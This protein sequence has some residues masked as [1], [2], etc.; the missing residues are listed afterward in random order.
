MA[1]W[2]STSRS[3]APA[4]ASRRVVAL[5]RTALAVGPEGRFALRVLLACTLFAACVVSSS[6]RAAEPPPPQPPPFTFSAS[7]SGLRYFS[8]DLDGGGSIEMSRALLS[9]GV[10]RQFVPAFSATLNMSLD[11]QDW[12]FGTP[13]AFGSQAPWQDLRQQ[14]M[15]LRL[16]QA[17]SKTLVV[18]VQPFVEWALET[19]V[20][21]SDAMTYG[22]LA[23]VVK[24]FSPKFTLGGGAKV[25]RMFYNVRTTPFFILNWKISERFRIANAFPASPAGGGGIEFRYTP[26]TAWEFGVGGVMRTD[27]YRLANPGPYPAHIAEVHNKPI[28]LRVSR[29]LGGGLRAD[30]YGA[31]LIGGNIEITDG[32]GNHVVEDGYGTVPALAFSLVGRF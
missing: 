1:D 32:D 11:Y 30:L 21:L 14:A 22:G 29:N 15:S 28:F 16:T 25:Q 23:S 4:P 6:A 20:D 19:G 3:G 7:A 12:K 17:L 8:A 27:R 18:G 5:R 31:G 2:L 9:V 24:V 26:T 13:T 10:T